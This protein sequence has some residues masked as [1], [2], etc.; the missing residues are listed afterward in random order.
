MFALVVLYLF[1]KIPS[2]GDV[3]AVGLRFAIL[4]IHLYT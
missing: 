4:R 3:Q 1:H 2:R